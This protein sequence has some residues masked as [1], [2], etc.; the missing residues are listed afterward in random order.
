MAVPG[1]VLA[2]ITLWYAPFIETATK[3]SR[4]SMISRQI[5]L[6]IDCMIHIST[7]AFSIIKFD[8]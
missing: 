8:C 1:A 3:T 2:I 6:S 5:R 7:L 4:I